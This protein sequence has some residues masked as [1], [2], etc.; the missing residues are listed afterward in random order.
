MLVSDKTVDGIKID[1]LSQCSEKRVLVICDGCGCVKQLIYANYRRSQE[2]HNRNGLT[3]C[4]S[5]ASKINGLKKRGKPAYNRGKKL[6]P[7]KKGENHPKWKGGKFI[8]SDGYVM[9][10]VGKSSDIGWQSY[11]KEHILIVEELLKRKLNGSE[12]IHH[13]DGDKL[14]NQVDNLYI[15]NS[16]GHRVAHASIQTIGYVLYKSGIIGFDKNKGTYFIKEG[17]ENS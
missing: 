5:C 7:D 15:T 17:Y 8:S 2:V 12:I 11:K 10:Y 14:N 16:T 1:E 6:P 9:R 13:I 3:Y 4:K